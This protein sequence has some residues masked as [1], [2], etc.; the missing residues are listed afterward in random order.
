MNDHSTKTTIDAFDDLLDGDTPSPDAL[1]K[2]AESAQAD[3]EAARDSVRRAAAHVRERGEHAARTAHEK[4]HAIG[5][6]VRRRAPSV[7]ARVRQELAV[8]IRW[9]V[10]GPILA[11]ST[12]VAGAVLAALLAWNGHR[13]SMSEE[14]KTMVVKAVP[15]AP[16]PSVAATEVAAASVAPTAVATPTPT[17]ATAAIPTQ[18]AGASPSAPAAPN[19]DVDLTSSLPALPPAPIEATVQN[20]TAAV[21]LLNGLFASTGQV[22]TPEQI[23]WAGFGYRCAQS[24]ALTYGNA[25][26]APRPSQKA[27]DEPRPMEGKAGSAESKRT[28]ARTPK[29][30][31]RAS[32]SQAPAVASVPQGATPALAAAPAS[33]PGTCVLRGTASTTEGAAMPDAPIEISGLDGSRYRQKINA[34][35]EGR[36]SVSVPSGARVRVMLRARGYRDDVRETL[37]CAAIALTGTKS[38]PL[39]SLFDA[40]RRADRSIKGATGGR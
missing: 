17:P 39:S 10:V 27:R 14:Q 2:V 35:A 37:G 11:G 15:E 29:P 4:A 19:V 28:P 9:R 32:K 34:D 26:Y 36:F 8:P 3:R 22:R 1:R 20:C 5:A 23:A 30:P 7:A 33:A 38:N 31:G 13:Y 24:G 25:G 16:A 6:S 18:S 21:P 40:A 12:V